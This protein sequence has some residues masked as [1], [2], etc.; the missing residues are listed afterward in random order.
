MDPEFLSAFSLLHSKGIYEGQRSVSE[1]RVLNLTRS[2]YAGQQRYGTV[3]WSGDISANWETLHKQIAEGLSF[4]SSGCPYWTLDIGG[5]FVKDW[6]QWYGDGRYN[7][8]TDDPEYRELYVRWFQY[9]TFL[10]M[11][12]SHGTDFAREVWRFGNE[13]SVEY[14]T[15]V[16]FI[17]LRYR[18]LPYI[19]SVAYEV[20]EKDGTMMRPL[21]A[22]FMDDMK[23]R[24]I[25]DQFMFGP[26]MMICPVYEKGC[27][28]RKVYLPEKEIWYDFWTGK[29]VVSGWQTVDTPL[30]QIPVYVRGGSIIP[31]GPEIQYTGQVVD[32]PLDI[33]VYPGADCTFT[34]YDDDG[35]TYAYERGEY[36]LRSIT[37]DD[38]AR[39]LRMAGEP[40]ANGVYR[41]ADWNT[42]IMG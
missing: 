31:M 1:K 6:M 30:S 28:S 9:G 11:M 35:E 39:T 40:F 41:C 13:N 26:A 5:F 29:R 36:A 4:V 32:T 12:R 21:A 22:D 7:T 42:R 37:W 14:Q 16:D 8:G 25:N 27:T 17:K 10:P 18:L 23:V 24:D 38:A 15:L 20:M 2:A 3:T 34:L 19:Y 33:C